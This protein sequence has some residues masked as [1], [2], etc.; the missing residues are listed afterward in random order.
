M[1][2]DSTP[3]PTRRSLAFGLDRIGLLALRFPRLA[4]IAAVLVSA[5]T[6]YGFFHLEIDRNLRDIFRG[7]TETYERY[8]DAAQDFVDPENQ[9]LVLVEGDIAAPD[10]L[11]TL[12][13]LQLELLFINNVGNVFSPFSLRTPPDEDGATQPLIGDP[14]DGLTP[15]TI[16]RIRAHPVLGDGLISADGDVLLFTLNHAEPLAANESHEALI[17]D[18]SDLVDD[19]LGDTGLSAE[20]AGF[21]AMRTETVRLL[22]RDQLVLNGSGI[23]IGFILS[24]IL[25]RSGIGAMITALPAAVA[26]MTILGWT[27]TLGISVTILSN[28]VPALVMV[29]GYADGMHLTYAW[30]KHRDAGASIVEAERLAL[31]EV[32]PAC[33]LTALTTAIA[34][35]SM[36][37]S[38]VGVVRDFGWVGAFGTIAA[39][40]IVLVGHGLLVRVFGRFW[41][42]ER[43][44]SLVEWLAGPC[45]SL[46]QW[47]TAR[48][49]ALSVVAVLAVLVT[50]IGFVI[51]PAENS[52][53]ETLPKDSAL[54][55]ALNVIDD[56]LGG[57]F[58]IQI[59]V[60]LGEG[61]LAVEDLDRIRS[62][63]EAVDGLGASRPLSLWSLAQWA[64]AEDGAAIAD[65]LQQLPDDVSRLFVGE[66]GALVTLNIVEMPTADTADLVDVVEEAATAALPGVIVTGATVFGAREATRTIGNLTLS[67]GIAV[68]VALVLLTIAVR[69]VGA[70]FVAAIP[71][72]L[73]IF[74]V[75][76]LLYVLGAGMQLTSIVSL[77]IAFGVAID[78]TIHYLNVFLQTERSNVRDRVVET[79]RRVGPV[80]IG[81]TFVLVGGM[82]M[83]QTSGLATVALFGLL[84]MSS[85]VVALFADLIFLTAIIAGPGRRLFGSAGERSE[86]TVRSDLT[87]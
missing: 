78:D 81:T 69:S 21:A 41:K 3:A 68:I 58:P 8:A 66:G 27:G 72:L 30:R 13:D 47:V 38:D 7:E 86:R 10:N 85:L 51:V 60:P 2:V 11:T 31:V 22:E 57:A 17:E 84:A 80:L 49:R 64:G 26:G 55:G 73:P 33:M 23:I 25:F 14:A 44:T 45:A 5:V 35:L 16:A 87:E 6:V 67:L 83:T 75:G 74:A 52:L 4:A 40:A 36:T 39:T 61:P 82:I 79:A 70:G 63:H 24:L 76:A 43:R 48:A 37:L 65:L 19:L 32:A 28:V 9:I 20:I 59:I 42:A 50:G 29:L 56:E 71:N 53:S 54:V 1:R 46:A 12:R 77:T 62:V 34:F 18:V 15:E